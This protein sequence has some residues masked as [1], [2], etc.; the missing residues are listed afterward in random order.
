MLEPQFDVI[1]QLLG[2]GDTPGSSNGV[3]MVDADLRQMV[4]VEQ[5]RLVLR[6]LSCIS[7]KLFVVQ[8]QVRSMVE[9]AYALG[10]TDVISR[11]REIIPKLVRIAEKPAQTD[12]AV[13][14]PELTDSAA[15][16]ASMFSAIR[17]GKPINLACCRAR[18]IADHRQHRT[19]RAKRVA[20]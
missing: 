7:E 17:D 19:K 14:A 9:Q 16:F 5:I 6:K 13:A 20:G 8:N 4:R 18:H 10:A 11:P 12:L 3:L 15:A 2:D 1:P